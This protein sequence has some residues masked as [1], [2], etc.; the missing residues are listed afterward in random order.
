MRLVCPNCGAQ[1]EVPEAVIPENGREVQCSN[2]GDTWFQKHPSQDYELAEELEQPLDEADWQVPD[3][4]PEPEPIE[5][6]D[7]AGQESLSDAIAETM[8]EQVP[9]PEA[10]PAETEADQPAEAKGFATPDPEPDHT[11]G[12]GP[13]PEPTRRELP[14]DVADVLREERNREIEARKHDSQTLETQPDLGLEAPSDAASRRERETRLRMARMRGLPDDAADTESAQVAAI[15]ASG[16]RRDLLPDI[17][18]INST[19]R[20]SGDRTHPG[21]TRGPERGVASQTEA[22]APQ[23]KRGFGR[24]FLY[25]LLLVALLILVYVYAPQIGKAV[26]VVGPALETYVGY[27]NQG[28]VWLDGQATA[29]MQWLDEMA[30][31]ADTGANTGS[32]TGEGQ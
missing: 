31:S 15:A 11:P 9:A 6:H 14:A 1:Y 17:E 26:P 7:P 30:A 25:A 10:A 22:G 24:G 12:H 4:Q 13:D 20:K 27:V 19:L 29:L 2:C 23:R 21:A 18:E 3:P 28:R 8:A 32:N 5:G 16:S